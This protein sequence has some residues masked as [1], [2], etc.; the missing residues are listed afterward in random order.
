MQSP[1]TQNWRHLIDTPE[2]VI[3]KFK[4]GMHIFLGTGAAEPRT[5]VRHL[6]SSSAAYWEDIELIQ[7]ISFGDA[8]SPNALQTQNFRLKTFFSGWVSSKAITAGWVD[9][10]PSRFTRIPHL[11][12]TGQ[13]PVDAAIVQVTPPNEAGFCSLGL[14]VDV[15]REAMDQAALKIA[16]INSLVPTTFG[17]TFVHMTEFD[18]LVMSDEPPIYF[19]RWEIIPVMDKLASNVAS[20]IEDGSCLAFS[21][22]AL[23]DALVKHLCKKRHLG[24]HSPFFTDAL[25]DLV[26]GGAVDNRRKEIHRGKALTSYAFGTPKLMKWLD[27]NPL[28]EFQ[29]IDRVFNPSIIGSNPNF[30]TVVAANQV[31]L[32]GRVGLQLG[33][34]NVASGPA[35]ILDFF[36]GAELSPG[37]HAIFALTSRDAN[38]KANIRLSIADSPN[39][40]SLF[41]SVEI[42][43]TEYGIANLQGHTLRERAQALIDITHPD[44]R[45]QLVEQAKAK[46]IL[47]ADQIYLAESAR[48]YPEDIRVTH[49]FKHQVDVEFRPIKPSD[50]EGM[51]QLFYRF[52][53]KSVYYRYFHTIRAMPHAKMQEYV[54]VDWNK[55]MSIVG[56]VG[57]KG[58]E[59]IVAEGRYDIYPNSAYAEVVFVV[60][61]KYQ[62]HGIATFLYKL[63][64]QVALERG[65][66]GFVAD[67]LFS[68]IGMMKVFKKGNLPVHI[69]L[70]EGVYHLQIP[71]YETDPPKFPIAI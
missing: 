8:I 18:F 20:L 58:L 32:Y 11:F 25:M 69:H 65:V 71:F 2:N 70:E 56:T 10:I 1:N 26:I 12:K 43:V 36:S 51:R 19:S 27:H 45:N 33:R 64:V 21:I 5:M 9:L 41:E 54:N 24:I 61:E 49:R 34:G 50:E 62:G 42:V 3:R 6:M 60:D 57:P 31:D 67:V 17:D 4:P 30:I 13:I 16:E 52:S 63:L 46:K 35:E 14:A 28:I 47:Y 39:L 44:D 40:F 15:A 38:G 66:K 55:V 7:L 22:G 68:N 37:G 29:R 53:D 23:Y 59:Q 48:L